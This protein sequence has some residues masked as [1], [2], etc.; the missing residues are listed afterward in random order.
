MKISYKIAEDNFGQLQAEFM[1]FTAFNKL[2][3]IFRLVAGFS[4]VQKA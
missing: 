2:K 4:K 1:K 3:K